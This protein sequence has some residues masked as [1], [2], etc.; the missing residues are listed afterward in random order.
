[1]KRT[2]I[3]CLMLCLLTPISIEAKKKL[4]GNGLFWEISDNGILTIS[5]RGEIPGYPSGRKT[6]WRKGQS[7]HTI[8]IEEGITYVGVYALTQL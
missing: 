1:M 4:F 5:G 3:A 6:P 8:I 2:I 7:V